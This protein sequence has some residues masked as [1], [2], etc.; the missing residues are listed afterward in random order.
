MIENIIL[1][2]IQ[3]IGICIP[4]TGVAAL[5]RQE[6]NKVS[7][8]L[9]LT[10]I[11]C[12]IM[13]VGQ[14]LLLSCRTFE[15]AMLAYKVGYFGST[16]FY[17]CFGLFITSY[18]SK[19]KTKWLF[20]VW[21]AI[22]VASVLALY[23]KTL[24]PFLFQVTFNEPSNFFFVQT[25]QITPGPLYLI[26]YC[27]IAFV[28]FVAMGMTLYRMFKMKNKREK[29]K[30]ARLEGAEFVILIALIVMLT[31]ELPYDIVPIAA[32]ASIITIILSVV[33]GEFFGIAE[34]GREWAF[35]QMGEAVVIV[36]DS[37]NFLDA[38]SYAKSIFPEI[39]TQSANTKISERI[40]DI[41]DGK[42]EEEEFGERIYEKKIMSIDQNGQTVGYSLLL[43]DITKQKQL[44]NRLEEEKTRADEAN[45][46]K[47]AFMSNMSHEIRTPMN[48][49]VGMTEILLRSKLPSQETEY[50]HNI[51]NSGNAL[52]TIIND[53][54]DFSKIESGKMDIVCEDYD[55]MSMFSDLSM[56]F[57]NRIGDKN[58]ELIF[59]IDKNLPVRLHGDS[60]R[61]RQ[62]IINL[63]NNAIKFTDAG[64]VK[65]IVK[66]EKK[67]DE[68][69][70]LLFSVIDTGQGIKEEDIPKLFGTY[71]QVDTKKNR[72][73]EGTGLGLSISKQLVEMMGGTI[74]VRS[75]YEKGSEFY[76]SLSQKVVDGR[77]IEEMGQ[78]LSGKK[79]AYISEG[80]DA[81]NFIAPDAKILIVDDNQMNL[82]VA[83]GL[84]EPLQLQMDTAEN[85]RQA[86]AMME[87]KRY[88][89]VFMDHM[90]PVMDGIE[91][92][93]T[94]RKKS[95]EYSKNVPVIALTANAVVEARARFM[96]AGMNDFLSKPIKIKEICDMLRKWLPVEYIIE[97]EVVRNAVNEEEIPE[98]EGLDVREGIQNSGTKE[99]F[100]SL[101]GDFYKLIDMKSVKIEKCLADGMI[102]DYTIEVHA[103]KNT[104]RMI[105]AMKLSQLFYQ[106][107][108]YGNEENVQALI[109]ETPKVMELYRSYKPIL[110]AYAKVNDGNKTEVSDEELIETL[111]K[112]REAMDTFDLDTADAIMEQLEQMQIPSECGTMMDELRAYVADVA[113][114]DVLRVAEKMI[115]QIQMRQE[116]K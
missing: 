97:T 100:L 108:Q 93:E 17:F 96:E 28:L 31:Q 80:E 56:I 58:I 76:F 30:L 106:M 54:L 32:S 83:L 63:M 12:L 29:Y 75:E 77:T 88:D 59:D 67:D 72:Y 101:L 87:N 60:L 35:E 90:M 52:L 20:V 5:L 110:E 73:K 78:T 45:Q 10:N 13:N 81:L 89:L 48:A 74:G 14:L 1:T 57:L 84:L 41:F 85:G 66:V 55:P 111:T 46:A 115:Q 104:A 68:K 99:L 103:L 94:L 69:V 82:K 8:Y 53:I 16:W 36:D 105:G 37:Y 25:I 70:G 38:N 61:I 114:E 39:K 112:L 34:W 43:V 98:I 71:Q 40:M 86:L 33:R 6:Q 113:M 64:S 102:R 3:I 24:N 11:G 7:T 2:I 95:D 18:L 9:M 47:S 21:G 91:A 62:I 51:K 50:L 49:I 23:I 116:E 65:L 26:R 22:E 109:E 19:F 15:A 42:N 79:T 107:E 27:A 44:M 92:V 4:L